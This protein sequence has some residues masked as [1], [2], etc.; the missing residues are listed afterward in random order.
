MYDLI[1]IGG[2]INGAGIARDAAQRGLSV[3]LLEKNDFASG[4]TQAPTRL[5]HG[6]LRYLEYFEIGLVFESLQEREALLRI[7][8]HL[9]KPLPFLIPIYRHSRRGVLLVNLG[10]VAYDLLSYHKSVPRYRRLNRAQTLALE[11]GLEPD[12]LLGGVLYYDAQV[13]W[14]ERLCLANALAA[15]SDG[16][17]VRNYAEV[18]GL[19]GDAKSV[20]GVQVRESLTGKTYALRARLVVNVAGPWADQITS[21]LGPQE[22][23]RIFPTKGTHLVVPKFAAAPSHAI[24]IEAKSDGR[25]YFVVPWADRYLIGTTDDPFTGDLDDVRPLE[26]E[27]QY[28]LSE[29]NQVFPQARLTTEDVLHTYSGL[30]ALPMQKGRTTSALS[31]RAFIHDHE[32]EEGVRGLISIIGGKLTAYRRLAEEVVDLAQRKLNVLNPK[33]CR[34]ARSPL[35]GGE[36]DALSDDLQS[37]VRAAAARYELH[38]SQVEHLIRLYGARY[39]DV[40]ALVDDAPQLGARLSR[41]APD[42]AAQAAY[43]VEHEMAVRLSDFFVRRSGLVAR[44]AGNEATLAMVAQV[45]AERLRWDRPTTQREC[46]AWREER[47]RLFTLQIDHQK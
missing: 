46:D 28:L 29:V 20:E 16:A 24:Y 14:P 9:V 32:K 23:R 30:R 47:A 33:P 25:P 11:P 44:D 22:P 41:S 43:A 1:V 39:R 31:R 7:A 42:I 13:E 38:A 5:I 35:P 12:G 2:G 10:M 34:T 8:P 37:E 3:A 27:A 36:M 19:L 6:G 21:L 45:F 4:T 17:F 15:R 40:L 26:D 18:V